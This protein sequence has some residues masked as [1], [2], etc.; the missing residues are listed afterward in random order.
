MAVPLLEVEALAEQRAQLV[1]R[2][3]H[4]NLA[5]GLLE[6]GEDRGCAQEARVVHHHFLLC[7]AVIEEVAGDA[8]HGRRPAGDDR[9]VVRVGETRDHRQRERV[10]AGLQYPIEVGA[11][12]LLDSALD[13]AGLG[14]VDTNDDGR[15]IRNAI[16]AAI[17]VTEA[18]VR[19]SMAHPFQVAPRGDALRGTFSRQYREADKVAGNVRRRPSCVS[20]SSSG[21]GRK[22]DR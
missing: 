17:V 1:L 19:V 10:R 4:R 2:G 5:A 3:H 12:P 13:V 9:Q 14:T 11:K 7:L 6:L 15:R 18:G 21:R 22:E 8:V 16:G 20:G